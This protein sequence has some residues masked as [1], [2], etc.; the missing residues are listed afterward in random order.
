MT[1]SEAEIIIPGAVPH[2]D[3][4]GGLSHCR[5]LATPTATEFAELS[6]KKETVG[7]LLKNYLELQDSSS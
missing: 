2:T 5:Q 6:V 4:N 1:W 7:A 3:R